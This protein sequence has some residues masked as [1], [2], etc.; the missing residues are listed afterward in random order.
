MKKTTAHYFDSAKRLP[1]AMSLA[2]VQALVVKVGV[3][4]NPPKSGWNFK[5]FIIMTSSIIALSTALL[6]SNVNSTESNYQSRNSA[7]KL[8]S[9]KSRHVLLD[10]TEKIAAEQNSIQDID[11]DSHQ[12]QVKKIDENSNQEPDDS[13]V[14]IF[15]SKL[16]LM[17]KKSLGTKEAVDVKAEPLALVEINQE[18]FDLFNSGIEPFELFDEP[19]DIEELV[20]MDTSKIVGSTKTINKQIQAKDIKWFLINHSKGDIEIKNSSNGMIELEAKVAIEAKNK[21]DEEKGLADFDL[22][23]VSKGNKVEIENSWNEDLGSCFCSSDSK[24]NKIKTS[25]GDKIQIKKMEINYVLKIPVDIGLDLNLKY[26]DI[27]LP[28]RKA[29]LKI[30]LFKG[31]LTAANTSGTF[32][33]N[34][35]YGKMNMGN[36][37]KGNISLFK[38]SLKLKEIPELEIKANYSD[39]KI[40]QTENLDLTAFK[41]DVEVQII[42]KNLKSNFRYGDLSIEGQT[43]SVELVAFKSNVKTGDIQQMNF[44]ASYSSLEAGSILNLNLIKAFQSKI[45]INEVG[46][47]NGKSNYTPIQIK[48]LNK[49]L[50]LTTFKGSIDI[51]EVQS[52]FKNI[53]L[54]AKYTNV[55][56]NFS[57]SSKY[58]LETKSTYTALNMPAQVQN[59]SINSNGNNHFNHYKGD[60]NADDSGNNSQVY[61]ESFQG[62]LDLR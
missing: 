44:D 58:Q 35:K 16:K 47:M 27:T 18:E 52:G 12:I 29:D 57:P 5:N 51:N 61:I 38:S 37:T 3:P 19:K 31:N 45:N 55:D 48:R 30:A 8:S 53:H 6:L 25:N 46:D 42:T 39:L 1:L 62:K 2:Q 36:A 15:H 33:L 21:E 54:N 32:E 13:G 24:K 22:N 56:L 17:N 4:T 9:E 7:L 28:D 41:T 49:N 43:E 40:L 50:E 23:L 14:E 34:G 20:S 59:L 26:G 11:G 10:S 60:V